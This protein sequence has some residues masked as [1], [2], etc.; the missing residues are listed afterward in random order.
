SRR[1]PRRNSD[2]VAHRSQDRGLQELLPD[3]RC[4]ERAYIPEPTLSAVTA[5][6]QHGAGERDLRV[7]LRSLRSNSQSDLHP[8]GHSKAETVSHCGQEK[9][10]RS[11]SGR[12]EA[13]GH[14]GGT[15]HLL[16][17]A[18]N[19][20]LPAG[21]NESVR[22]RAWKAAADCDAAEEST[23]R[24]LSDPAGDGQRPGID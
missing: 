11:L 5:V 7:S 6:E 21:I 23:G 19:A 14:P 10:N 2:G 8:R 12:R 15:L 9:T 22:P 24:K 1:H 4:R 17:I 3:F 16:S 18:E 13:R 20:S